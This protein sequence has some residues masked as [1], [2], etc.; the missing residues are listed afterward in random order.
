[1]IALTRRTVLAG[2]T[3]LAAIPAR[4][5][6]A[7]PSRPITLV[8]GYVAGGSDRRR[9]EDLGRRADEAPRSASAGRPE[10]WS[11]RNGRGRAGRPCRARRPHAHRDSRRAC[12]S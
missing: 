2:L 4:P 10:T 6:P 7:W 1:M 8:H 9:R 12:D 11:V 5:D 3:T